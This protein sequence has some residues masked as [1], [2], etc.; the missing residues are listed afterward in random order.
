[1]N[2]YGKGLHGQ[3]KRKAEQPGGVSLINLK[4]NEREV[5]ARLVKQGALHN[6][7]G[8]LVWQGD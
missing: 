1:M 4:P 2:N 8:K 6:V 3:V 5:A 7:G